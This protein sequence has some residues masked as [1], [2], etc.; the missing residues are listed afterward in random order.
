MHRKT[1]FVYS[2]FPVPEVLKKVAGGTVF[3]AGSSTISFIFLYER[4]GGGDR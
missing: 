4:R 2:H 1:I 3:C